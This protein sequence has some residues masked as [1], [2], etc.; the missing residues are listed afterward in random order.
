MKG[1]GKGHLLEAN[2][3]NA[4]LPILAHHQR[5]PAV[6]QI[7][8]LATV[9]LKAGDPQCQALALS[10]GKIPAQNLASMGQ[11]TDLSWFPFIDVTMGHLSDKV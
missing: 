11:C 6:Q 3:A 10:Q 2:Y 7:I 1:E 4:P 8:Q 9:D 5:L